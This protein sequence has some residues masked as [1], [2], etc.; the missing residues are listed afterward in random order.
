[1]SEFNKL[2][3]DF[4]QQLEKFEQKGLVI[5][6]RDAFLLAVK[7]A[8]YYRLK[9]YLIPYRERQQEITSNQLLSLYAFDRKLRLLFLDAIDRIEIALKAIVSVH[10][11]LSYGAF[12]FT[13]AN[14]VDEAI[15]SLITNHYG[16]KDKNHKPIDHYYSKYTSPEY[17][18]SWMIME[19]IGMGDISK[20]ISKL[21]NHDLKPLAQFFDHST[22]VIKSWVRS[23][24]VTR[25][26]CAHHGRFWDRIYAISPEKTKEIE[27]VAHRSSLAE[28]ILITNYLVSKVCPE[29]DFYEQV[30]QLISD[31]DHIIIQEK[32]GF[33]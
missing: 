28:Q 7:T 29:M 14:H 1:M 24:T 23:L 27:N 30:R 21:H 11:S 31:Y 33:I 4:Q 15:T 32:I 3:I 22:R 9:G 8:G 18:P 13:D 19:V 6:D 12:W 16:I 10:M 20:I 5:D 25:N 26:I 17:P 2:S